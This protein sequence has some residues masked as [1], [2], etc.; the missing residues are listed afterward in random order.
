M[1]VEKDIVIGN[2]GFFVMMLVISIFMF[3]VFLCGYY[4][5][6]QEINTRIVN[7]PNNQEE[8]FTRQEVDEFIY[9]DKP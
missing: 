7:Y 4:Y 8:C 5:K 3:V 2:V 9:G 6:T 1:I